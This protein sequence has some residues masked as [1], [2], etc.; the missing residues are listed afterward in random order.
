LKPSSECG[1]ARCHLSRAR[2]LPPWS[3]EELAACFVVKTLGTRSPTILKMS[4]GGDQ[5]RACSPRGRGAAHRSQHRQ[6]AGVAKTADRITE[7]RYGAIMVKQK[8]L[9]KM[10]KKAEKKAA[11]KAKKI[12]TKVDRSDIKLI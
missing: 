10:A 11:K 5:H 9:R 4:R 2:S 8:K 3:I 6:A 12:K 7:T 1:G